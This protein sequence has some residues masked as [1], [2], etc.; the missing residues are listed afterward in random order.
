MSKL[1]DM[2]E[3]WRAA[4]KTYNSLLDAGKTE[5]A[6]ITMGMTI[7]IAKCIAIYLGIANDREVM[8]DLK[9]GKIG[10]NED[11]AHAWPPCEPTQEDDWQPRVIHK[12]TMTEDEFVASTTS[13]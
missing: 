8:A 13:T 5:L 4:D 11:C 2:V 1:N 3:E 10:C 7:G 12:P 6:A 9:A